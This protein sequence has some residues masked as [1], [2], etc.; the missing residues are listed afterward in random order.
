LLALALVGGGVVQWPREKVDEP[1]AAS[2]RGLPEDEGERPVLIGTPR[3]KAVPRT[4]TPER[5]RKLEMPKRAPGNQATLPERLRLLDDQGRPL[6][7]VGVTI[8]TTAREVTTSTDREGYVGSWPPTDELLGVRVS[9]PADST[10]FSLENADDIARLAAGTLVLE[11]VMMVVRT[12]DSRGNV[13]PG[14]RILFRMP[15]PEGTDGTGYWGETTDAKGLQTLGPFASG[16]RVQLRPGPR[17]ERV[18]FPKEGWQTFVADGSQVDLVVR[19]APRLRLR[20]RGATEGEWVQVALLDAA[21]GRPL[22]PPGKVQEGKIW[23]A[24]AL[25]VERVEVVAGPTESGRFVRMRDVWPT[26]E[27]VDVGLLAGPSYTGRVAGWGLREPLK[28]FVYVLGRGFQAKVQLATDGTFL[29]PG[30]PDEPLRFDTVLAGEDRVEFMGTFE[31]RHEREIVIPVEPFVRLAG[32]VE[33]PDGPDGR[34]ALLVVSVQPESPTLPA[35]KASDIDS[36]GQFKF[37]L[38]PGPWRLKVVA[39]SKDQSFEGS[40]DLGDVRAS[41]EDLVIRVEPVQRK[42]GMAASAAPTDR[43]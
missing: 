8:K 32:R 13:R 23:T 12:V 15:P 30:G 3:E 19:D 36:S 18:E 24:P 9:G 38:P 37:W 11:T 21:D 7:H 39:R 2:A 40:L 28:G 10:L 42:P 29:W 4:P 14:E 5:P 27:P 26:E 25:A 35:P 41:R 20:V 43:R 17:G 6:A 34:P 1:T 16:A 31:R 22:F 33:A